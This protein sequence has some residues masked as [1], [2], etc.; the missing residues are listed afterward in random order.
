M[1]APQ[2][3]EVTALCTIEV[4]LFVHAKCLQEKKQEFP[5]QGLQA[6]QQ[7]RTLLEGEN[8]TTFHCTG[9]HLSN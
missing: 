7:A 5:L 6:R 8:F 2:S 4:A 3:I 9:N 1:T